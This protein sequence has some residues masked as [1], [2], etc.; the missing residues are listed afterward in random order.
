MCVLFSVP[1]H[2]NEDYRQKW[3]LISW[4]SYW[5]PL[6]Y[7][8][9]MHAFQWEKWVGEVCLDL[10]DFL[11]LWW[12]TICGQCDCELIQFTQ[13]VG[14]RVCSFCLHTQP[15]WSGS[16]LNEISTSSNNMSKLGSNC[17]IHGEMLLLTACW[18]NESTTW[19]DGSL[20]TLR[21]TLPTFAHLAQTSISQQMPSQKPNGRNGPPIRKYQNYPT[22]TWDSQKAKWVWVARHRTFTRIKCTSLH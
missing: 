10:K 16:L 20:Q 19:V 4:S 13:L 7:I 18:A 9:C 2:L 1:L 14:F 11:C 12:H 5:I 3:Q 8:P 6:A 17:L 22:K 15:I 21:T